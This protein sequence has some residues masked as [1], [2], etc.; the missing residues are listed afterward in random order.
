[1]FK[2]FKKYSTGKKIRVIVLLLVLA[3]ALGFVVYQFVKP[4]P[5]PEYEIITVEKGSINQTY[6]ATGTVE[7][8]DSGVYT[9]LDGTEV[10]SLNVKVGD[11]VKKGT[12]L[13]TF[14]TSGLA[15]R[16]NEVK[17][18]YDEAKSRYN[19]AVSSSN[20][21][22]KNLKE[23]NSEINRV[24]KEIASLEKEIKVLRE[25]EKQAVTEATEP[26]KDVKYEGDAYNPDQIEELKKQIL[27]N[28]GTQEQIDAVI[29][30]LNGAEA[31]AEAEN[32][33]PEELAEMLKNTSAGK[34]LE[35]LQLQTQLT[36]LKTQQSYF[37]M[38][39]GDTVAKAFKAIAD[40]K[41]KEYED[42]K[43]AV[44]ALDKGWFAEGEGIVTKVNITQ[45][46]VY[47]SDK[48]EGAAG[49]D[50]TEILNMVAAGQGD[51]TSLLSQLGSSSADS[52]GIQ[53]DYY[54]S[55]I[56]SFNVG[57]YDLLSLK[58][59]QEAK[60][61][62]LDSE[63]EGVV[64]Y[65]SATATENTGLDISSITSSLTGGSSS[66]S[67]A[68]AKVRIINPDEK[69][70]IGFDV[71][72]AVNI[73]KVDNVVVLPVEALR[74]ENGKKYVFVFN[75]KTGQVEKREVQLGRSEDTKYEIASGLETGEKV[76]KNPLS[77]LTDGAEISAK[78]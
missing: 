57:K 20:E 9:I 23:T 65:V 69:I 8:T 72:I 66:S 58:V 33:T 29:S 46:T 61:T 60:I 41:E 26:E 70:I 76:V 62:S 47:T 45:G 67:S 10:I 50:F 16:L 32:P 42:L 56:A 21:S 35:L 24:E 12:Q 71:D 55:F 73:D 14:D 34:S 2:K 39:S 7:S 36:S 3:G 48:K 43:K 18:E 40:M 25:S 19:S 11:K 59:G 77:S 64:E 75:E 31:A 63:Y 5:L 78:G 30:A 52:I 4:D 74:F 17:D 53:V 54:D 15:S 38:Q 44:D 6:T 27:D 68:L 51:I 1:V 37:E 22:S 28:G 13:A 49:F